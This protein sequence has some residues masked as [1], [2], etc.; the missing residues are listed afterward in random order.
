MKKQYIVHAREKLLITAGFCGYPQP[1]VTCTFDG[2][3]LTSANVTEIS[4]HNYMYIFIIPTNLKACERKELSC[5]A[6]GGFNDVQEN[7]M[8]VG[9]GKIVIII[10]KTLRQHYI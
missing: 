8:V 10:I 5:T 1:T 6:V 2:K 3:I 4:Q 7:V 9:E